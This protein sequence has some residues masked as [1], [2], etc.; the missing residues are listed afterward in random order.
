MACSILAAKQ[1]QGEGGGVRGPE[2]CLGAESCV[3]GGLGMWLGLGNT[4]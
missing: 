2:D 1:F 3:K 4:D